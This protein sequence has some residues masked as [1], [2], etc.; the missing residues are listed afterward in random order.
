MRPLPDHRNNGTRSE[1]FL[2]ISENL[3]RNLERV[4]GGWRESLFFVAL[5]GLF[6]GDTPPI[7]IEGVVSFD[8]AGFGHEHLHAYQFELNTLI[9]PDNLADERALYA[10]G[11]DKDECSLFA[12]VCICHGRHFNTI[13][14]CVHRLSLVGHPQHARAHEIVR[15]VVDINGVVALF[16][17][18]IEGNDPR[19][20]ALHICSIRYRIAVALGQ[21]ADGVPIRVSGIIRANEGDGERARRTCDSGKLDDAPRPRARRAVDAR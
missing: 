18:P 17:E 11:F 16:R 9:A 20:V 12:R 19:T 2:E 10:V 3:C 7:W 14:N 5:D 13:M 15:R 1:I 4:F 6:A 21:I 8:V